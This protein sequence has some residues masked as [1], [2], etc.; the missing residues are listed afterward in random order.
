M[1]KVIDKKAPGLKRTVLLGSTKIDDANYTLKATHNGQR[2]LCSPESWSLTLEVEKE[3]KTSY[4]LDLRTPL[5]TQTKLDS[6]HLFIANIRLRSKTEPTQA[7]QEIMRQHR[8]YTL[9]HTLYL[10]ASMQLN[11]REA[12]RYVDYEKQETLNLHKALTKVK[13]MAAD[14]NRKQYQQAMLRYK[15]FSNW[16]RV[17]LAIWKNKDYK[18]VQLAQSLLTPLEQ[19]VYQSL[20]PTEPVENLAQTLLQTAR[21]ALYGGE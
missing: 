20:E 12:E 7:V 15:A 8:A 4:S 11:L 21:F 14:E 6:P 18:T 19:A 9:L 2:M 10:R 5:L 3:A 13:L 1:N 16:D 17:G